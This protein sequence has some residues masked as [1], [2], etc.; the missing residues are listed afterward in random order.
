M[1]GGGGIQKISNTDLTLIIR[2]QMAK[3]NLKMLSLKGIPHIKWRRKVRKKFCYEP[4]GKSPL[5]FNTLFTIFS[6][7]SAA[8]ICAKVARDKALNNWIFPESKNCSDAV[9]ADTWGSGYPGD[10]VTKKFLRDNMNP[11]KYFS[12]QTYDQKSWVHWRGI[13]HSSNF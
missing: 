5:R 9:T 7:V 2:V 10:A 12:N 8:S 13:I 6:C 3:L 11:S 4:F 1:L